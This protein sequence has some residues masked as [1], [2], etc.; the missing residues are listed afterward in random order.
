MSIVIRDARADDEAEWRQLWLA[1]ARFYQ[2][3]VPDD[4]TTATWRRILDPAASVF[5]RLAE[6]DGAVV[7]FTV[8]VLHDGTWTAK[9][10]CYLE[11]LFVA[12]AVRGGGIGRALIEDLIA[13]C[14][15]RGWSRLYWHTQAENRTARRLYDRFGLADGFVRYRLIFE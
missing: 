14:H 2:V 6:V 15:A 5:A 3:D 11:D 7:G 8:C 13:L 4:A 1:Y 10:L 9:P 12:S